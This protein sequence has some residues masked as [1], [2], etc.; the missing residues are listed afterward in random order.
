VTPRKIIAVGLLLLTLSGA[1]FAVVEA[2]G[3]PSAAEDAAITRIVM[4]YINGEISRDEFERQSH[5]LDLGL[6]GWML[7]P[8][9]YRNFRDAALCGVF[10]GLTLTLA[11][12]IRTRRRISASPPGG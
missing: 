1:G 12:A 4:K 6:W 10:A 8:R 2:M 9:A 3:P 7:I 11:G 5:D